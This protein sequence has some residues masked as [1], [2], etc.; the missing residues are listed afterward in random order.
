V[1]TDA[2]PRYENID[3][4]RGVAALLVI[5]RHCSDLM[6]SIPAARHTGAV[7]CRIS[8]DVDLGRVGVVAFFAISGFVIYPTIRGTPWQGTR[9]FL[10]RRFFRIY[11]AYWLSMVLGYFVLWLAL[12]RSLGV[13]QMV[14]NAS[15]L[16]SLFGAPYIMG[17]YWT[18]E[19]EIVFYVLIVALFL[20]R[21]IRS[22]LV[23]VAMIVA[24]IALQV[25]VTLRWI[26]ADGDPQWRI[27]G[28]NLATMFWGALLRQWHD[29]PSPRV[30]LGP[31]TLRLVTLVASTTTL[32]VASL[33]SAMV[34]HLNPETLPSLMAHL[35]G[36]GMFLLTV[37]FVRRVP[38]PMAWLGTISYSIYLLHP[39]VMYPLWSAANGGGGL[40]RLGIA[41]L[42]ALTMT[43]AIA[44]AALSYYAVEKP[45]IAL[46]RRLTRH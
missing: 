45:A 42:M 40:A 29:A 1:Q 27:I 38:R 7:L 25:L 16:P 3:A 21:M 36:L 46:G 26:S 18:L 9:S 4:L 10:I 39:V 6:C 35:V 23:L 17:Q 41:P 19:V 33:I 11:P 34:R 15:M 22:P 37:L 28:V 44:A 20:S 32:F 12:D 14:A 43:C 2:R 5:A 13:G 24:C 30:A 31:L 8:E